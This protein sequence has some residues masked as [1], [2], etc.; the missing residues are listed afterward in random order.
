MQ[1]FDYCTTVYLRGYQSTLST[2]AFRFND[3]WRFVIQRLC[4]LAS[5]LVYLES[6]KLATRE[7]VA[8]LLGGRRA[9]TLTLLADGLVIVMAF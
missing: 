3:H 6:E 2:T 4:F 7:S 9:R 8:E 1:E 5:L